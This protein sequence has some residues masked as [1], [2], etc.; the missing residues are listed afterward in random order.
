VGTEGTGRINE[1]RGGCGG[2]K[3]WSDQTSNG[4]T[5]A[6]VQMEQMLLQQVL[7]QFVGQEIVD[8][9]GSAAGEN[10]GG[11]MC[12]PDGPNQRNRME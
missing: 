12:H 9:C 10:K 8:W 2:L 3:A 5:F 11:I 7:D 4:S 1:G 6:S